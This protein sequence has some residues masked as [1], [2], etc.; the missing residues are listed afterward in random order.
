MR[1][2]LT[3]L[4]EKPACYDSMWLWEPTTLPKANKNT[5]QTN[6]QPAN[7]QLYALSPRFARHH[8]R[9][10]GPKAPSSKRPR[11]CGPSE[12]S[13]DVS[14]D[15]SL[16]LEEDGLTGKPP[17]QR[18]FLDLSRS[19]WPLSKS[20]KYKV[21]VQKQG[22]Q[23][24]STWLLWRTR[25]ILWG[26]L[27]TEEHELKHKGLFLWYSS[28]SCC[29]RRWNSSKFLLCRSAPTKKVGERNMPSAMATA[30]DRTPVEAERRSGGDWDSQK[31][32]S[33]GSFST[34]AWTS[35]K[36]QLQMIHLLWACDMWVLNVLVPSQ[37]TNTV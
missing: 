32:P 12:L 22:C 19:F 10:P 37:E 21:C 27:W 9:L 26:K 33:R 14:F 15:K 16:K 36:C 17:K 23:P 13:P 6:W 34:F 5:N 29:S 35:Y 4:V 3:Q 18:K 30:R 25:K 20:I 8:L 24:L 31:K 2:T 11:R 28:A 7:L 1:P